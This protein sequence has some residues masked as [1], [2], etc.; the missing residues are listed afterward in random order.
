MGTLTV[1]TAAGTG[2]LGARMLDY[3]HPLARGIYRQLSG[4]AAASTDEVALTPAAAR[5]LGVGVGGSVRLADGSR[6]FR[7]VGIVEDPEALKATTIVLRPGRGPARGCRMIGRTS[8]GWW[9]RRAR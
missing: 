1:D 3:T 8:G 6:T 7:V 9:P 4:R 5:R 2:N